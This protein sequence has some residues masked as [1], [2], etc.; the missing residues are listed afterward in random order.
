MSHKGSQ[1]QHQGLPRTQQTVPRLDGRMGGRRCRLGQSLSTLILKSSF[2][3]SY[4]DVLN[5]A[6]ESSL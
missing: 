2:G 3:K 5:G 4:S 1:E 6:I